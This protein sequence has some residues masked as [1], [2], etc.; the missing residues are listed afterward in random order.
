M[1]N[2]ERYERARKRVEE[3][4]GFYVHLMVFL[5]VNTGLFT[6]D[7][8]GSPDSTWF[9]WPL[10]GWGIGLAVHAAA[11][12]ADSRFLGPEWEERKAR[13]IVARD[14]HQIHRHAA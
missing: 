14:E 1:E 12:F 8:V 3:I 6:I 2:D 9:H 13:E 5:A 10:L 7:L 11:L 4:K